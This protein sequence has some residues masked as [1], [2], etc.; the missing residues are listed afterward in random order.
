MGSSSSKNDDRKLFFF[1]IQS[2]GSN[3]MQ[4]LFYCFILFLFSTLK[5]FFVDFFLLM[6]YV[7][8]FHVY[9]HNYFKIHLRRRCS[10]TSRSSG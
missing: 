2:G 1:S 9:I 8:S 10:Q 4:D 3:P 7:L 5:Y 6:I